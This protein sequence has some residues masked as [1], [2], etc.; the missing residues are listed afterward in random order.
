MM[1][2]FFVCFRSLALGL[3]LF[4]TLGAYGAVPKPL[5]QEAIGKA[6]ANYRKLDRLE[7]QFTQTK[8]L[9]A[10]GL[11][12]ESKG[13]MALE[14]GEVLWQLDEPSFLKLRISATSLEMFESPTQSKGKPLIENQEALARVLKPL[15]A[16]L[17]M[18]AALLVEQYQVF[19]EK[20]WFRLIPLDQSAPV[21]A[22]RLHLT[23][24]K[25][26]DQVELEES[27]GD[28]LQLKFSR[29]K[30]DWKK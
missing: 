17:T 24:E 16:W 3:L 23:K 20:D 2:N 19:S 4:L 10:M 6:L 9:R 7:S 13:K 26:V 5:D 21:R 22:L 30:V 27:S 15:Y 8:K 18:D 29:T 14:K 28:E 25:L 11:A 12:L 1:A